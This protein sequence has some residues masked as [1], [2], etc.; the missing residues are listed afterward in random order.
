MKTNFEHLRKYSDLM[1]HALKVEELLL[2]KG[3]MSDYEAAGNQGRQ[4]LE[5]VVYHLFKHYGLY[6]RN[7]NLKCNMDLLLKFGIISTKTYNKMDIVRDKA[8]VKSHFRNNR[9]RQYVINHMTTMYE[10]LYEVTYEM[11]AYYLT[12]TALQAYKSRR[13]TYFRNSRN[14]SSSNNYYNYRRPNNAYNRNNYSSVGQKVQ[15][16]V[17]KEVSTNISDNQAQQPRYGGALAGI[18]TFVAI[19]IGA[20]IVCAMM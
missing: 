16:V 9:N 20:M 18:L 8:N 12:D 6:K 10:L 4:L 11:T 19:V 7:N 13:A 14:N 1:S 17:H 5:G 2:K 15:P 3:T